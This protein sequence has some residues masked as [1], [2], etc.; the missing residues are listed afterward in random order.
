MISI[1]IPEQ[2]IFMS[3]LL[4][5][6][7]FDSYFLESA[8]IDTYNS[9]SIDGRIHKEFFKDIASA[10]EVPADEFSRWSRIRPICLDLIKGRQT[11]LSFKFVLLADDETRKRILR[12]ADSDISS[13]L[14]LLGLN[15]RFSNG[16][17]LVT[18]GTSMKIFSTDKSAEK[19]WD[20]YIPSFLESNSIKTDTDQD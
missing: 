16:R 7:L 1:T 18:T 4:A 2:K 14:I 3:K 19:A 17:M 6:E 13:D 10:E 11:P 8:S 5:S 15:I 12:E 20:K 9:F